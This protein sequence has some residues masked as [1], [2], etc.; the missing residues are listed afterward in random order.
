MYIGSLEIKKEKIDGDFV[1]VTMKDKS[2][3]V[4]HKELLEKIKTDE[5]GN[6]NVTDIIND[7]F[8][9]KFLAEL[10]YYDLDYMFAMNVGQ[11]I[12]TLAHNLREGLIS[13]TFNCSGGDTIKLSKIL[14]DEK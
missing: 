12:A 11:G 4:V 2:S 9:R 13:R 7:Y 3:F 6:G 5:K 14:E 1:T 10:A 8:S